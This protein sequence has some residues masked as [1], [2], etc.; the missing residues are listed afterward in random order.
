LEIVEKGL[1]AGESAHIYYYRSIIYLFL[2]MNTEALED[3]D[4]AIEKSEDNVAK[5]FHARGV[6][7]MLDKNYEQAIM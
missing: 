4:R 7:F 1:R 3:I 6:I 5:Y 2:G